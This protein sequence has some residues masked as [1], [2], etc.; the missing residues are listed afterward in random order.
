MNIETNRR[1]FLSLAV[2]VSVLAALA[3]PSIGKLVKEV[4]AATNEHL[5]PHARASCDG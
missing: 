1:A 3:V 5:P 2:K 4:E